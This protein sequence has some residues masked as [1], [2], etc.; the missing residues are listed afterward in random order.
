MLMRF[1]ILIFVGDAGRW[2]VFGSCGYF[3]MLA[4]DSGGSEDTAAGEEM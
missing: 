3:L 4:L 2:C 1:Y